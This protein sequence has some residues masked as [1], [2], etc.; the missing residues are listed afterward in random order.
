VRAAAILIFALSGAIVAAA[1]DSEVDEEA[2]PRTVEVPPVDVQLWPPSL[3]TL[4]AVWTPQASYSDRRGLG[5]GAESLLAFRLDSDPE[6]AVS[7]LNLY[8][9]GTTKGQW[10]ANLATELRW[11]GGRYYAR[12]RLDHDDLAREFFGLG[13]ASS[14]SDP[15]VYRPLST[16]IYGEGTVSVGDHLAL[17]PR[18][19]WQRQAVHDER[20]DGPLEQVRGSAASEVYGF[21]LRASFDT[22]DCRLRACRGVYLQAMAMTFPEDLGD[23]GFRLVNVDLRGFLPLT[24]RQTLAVQ[25]FGYG[26]GGTPPFWRL[27]SLGGRDHS[28]AY[29]RD[30][31]LDDTL[32][33]AQAEWRWRPW[34]HVGVVPFA[35]VATVAG[36]P[37]GWQLRYLRP[38]LGLGLRVFPGRGPA[39]VPI[40][41]DLAV[42]HRD[43]RAVLALGEAF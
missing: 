6:A 33:S 29:P 32:L 16:L 8:F 41:L 3:S 12:F 11:G 20:P 1:Q 19:E 28:R 5:L 10:R 14:G 26:V 35:G 39:T 24:A 30:R 36:A 34:R 15:E 37:S 42:G 31:W 2:V 38:S 23:H 40:R 22:R 17:G 7:T 21:G 13:P 27:A 25:L 4:G 18:V 43:W 9:K